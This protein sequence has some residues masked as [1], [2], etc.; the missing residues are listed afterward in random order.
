MKT[1]TTQE[2]DFI[3]TQPNLTLHGRYVLKI[4]TQKDDEYTEVFQADTLEQAEERAQVRQNQ[5]EKST[6]VESVELFSPG[7]HNGSF[8][9]ASS[10]EVTV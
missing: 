8:H 1:H 2:E 6:T 4:T 10:H 9:K 3:Q 5:A 7:S